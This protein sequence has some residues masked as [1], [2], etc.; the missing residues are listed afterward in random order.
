MLSLTKQ[1]TFTEFK[2]N[3]YKTFS[4]LEELNCQDFNLLKVVLDGLKVNYF[5]KNNLNDFIFKP[6]FYQKIILLIKSLKETKKSI[7]KNKANYLLFDNGKCIVDSDGKEHSY[8]LNNIEQEL[9][10]ENCFT[11][12]Q[13]NNHFKKE[14]SL[15]LSDI[16]NHFG[17]QKYSKIEVELI[18][19][20]RSTFSNITK[21]YNLDKIDLLNIKT[22]FNNFFLQYCLFN[23]FFKIS[24][25]THC[26][27]D[28]HYHREGFI[29]AQ[30]R[31]NIQ[32]IE[33]QHGLIAEQDIF[34]VF[35]KPIEAIRERALFPDKLFCYGQYWINVVKK[36]YE[37]S[38]EQL[39]IIGLYQYIKSD[40]TDNEKLA[41]DR[42][43]QN[44]QF[45][46]ITTQTFLHKEFID[47]INF[48]SNDLINK[49]SSLKIIVKNHPS[50]KLEL[51]ESI[52]KLINCKVFNV[53]VE[54]LLKNCTYHVSI[55]ST[56]LYDALKYDCIN[57]ALK[58]ESCIDYVLNIIND[59]IALPLNPDQS[60]LDVSANEKSVINSKFFYEDF[61][62]HKYKLLQ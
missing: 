6:L 43:L 52:N 50:E 42:F 53:N 39:D 37:F 29:L 54:Y 11:I 12:F 55:Y 60:L 1:I 49:K 47:Y 56:T 57:Y 16:Q 32:S 41:L 13:T 36:G 40:I 24:N 2:T 61:N 21:K 58:V 30:K 45:I 48:L 10:K 9:S 23:R 14:G 19:A 17:N 28:Q 7:P 35:P 26:F 20:L 33:L 34:Y 59:G 46:L 3:F 38:H 31:N 8:Y 15:M 62:A 51:Y 44:Q 25:F 18:F 22:A 27:F 5:Q 4:N